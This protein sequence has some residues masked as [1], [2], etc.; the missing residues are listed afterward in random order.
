MKGFLGANILG[1]CASS[2]EDT[3]KQER[4]LRLWLIDRY[5][6]VLLEYGP[7]VKYM[8]R[9]HYVGKITGKKVCNF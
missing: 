5:R 2:S 3:K 1:K 9:K 6:I 8:V 4:P 7:F